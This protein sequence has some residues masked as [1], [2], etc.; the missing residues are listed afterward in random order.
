MLITAF[1]KQGLFWGIQTI[2]Q[3]LPNE[4]LRDAKV[5]GVEWELPCT[6]ITDKPRF[7]WRGLMIDYSRTFWSVGQT[8]K[9]IDALSYYKMNK[10]HMHLTD[11]QGW[12]IEIDKYPMLTEIAST[13]FQ[14]KPEKKP[15]RGMLSS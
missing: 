11:D 8:K 4:I 13:F 7:K 9:Y 6:N 2:R 1:N 15:L 14:G 12:R 10:L 3:L 5:E